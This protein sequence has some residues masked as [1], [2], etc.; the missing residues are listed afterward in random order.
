M[1][2]KIVSVL[3]ERRRR[4]AGLYVRTRFGKKEKRV[5]R[6][7]G[8]DG[9]GRS[10]TYLF[11]SSR[12][13]IFVGHGRVSFVRAHAMLVLFFVLDLCYLLFFSF[14][15]AACRPGRRPP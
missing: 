12:L 13:G 7:R 1:T 14:G 11:D 4:R 2:R 8:L 10:C 15:I 3:A 9:K 5:A 6:T